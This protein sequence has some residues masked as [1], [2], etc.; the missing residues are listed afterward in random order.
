METGI[1]GHSDL[2]YSLKTTLPN[3][4]RSQGHGCACDALVRTI[5]FN[6]KAHAAIPITTAARP[7]NSAELPTAAL[8]VAD[9]GAAADFDAL[10]LALCEAE[11]EALE[12]EREAEAEAEAEARADET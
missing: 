5:L 10:A 4:F 2:I 12:A 1:A 8:W 9:A 3:V 6:Y 11:A 7:L